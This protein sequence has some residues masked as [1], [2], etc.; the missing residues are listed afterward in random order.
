MRP[1]PLILAPTDLEEALKPAEGRQSYPAHGLPP[2]SRGFGHKL[3]RVSN[4]VFYVPSGLTDY[5][6]SDI[7]IAGHVHPTGGGNSIS[8]RLKAV[9][10]RHR[11]G[12]MAAAFQEIKQSLRRLYLDD[13]RPWLAGFS[14]G[15]VS[16]GG[17]PN[18][19]RRTSN[20]QVS[21]ALRTRRS[22][23]DTFS[24]CTAVESD[25][26]SEGLLARGDGR[27]EK[28]IEFGDGYETRSRIVPLT[29]HRKQDV[30][31]FSA[32]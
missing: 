1:C 2:T 8:S 19:E 29:I 7:I 27:T 22:T 30:C 18:R 20:D 10:P 6:N 13:P 16:A 26:A 9:A 17:I 28:L 3:L 14:G 5:G 25:K 15:K 11:L 21:P 31:Y 4:S 23:P 32:P 24:A 12:V